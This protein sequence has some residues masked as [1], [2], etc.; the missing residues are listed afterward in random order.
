MEFFPVPV[1]QINNWTEHDPELST[2]WRFVKQG[3]PN[4]VK[5]ELCPYH[6]RRLEISIQDGCQL[7]GS[8]IIVPELRRKRTTFVITA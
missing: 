2:V 8:W 5:P 1:K 7:W 3:W 4:L 6:S